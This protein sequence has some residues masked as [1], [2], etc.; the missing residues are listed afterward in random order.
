MSNEKIPARYLIVAED[1]GKEV[2]LPN[3]NALTESE[4]AEHDI[5]TI[6]ETEDPGQELDYI[7]DFLADANEYDLGPEVVQ[8]ALKHMQRNPN[9]TPAMAMRYGYLEW[10][11]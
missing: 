4:L 2:W 9:L 10:V 6:D 1:T 7:S 8:F 11:K 3:I 5:T